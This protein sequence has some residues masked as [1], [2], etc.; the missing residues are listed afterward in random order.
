[1]RRAEPSAATTSALAGPC[2]A[3]NGADWCRPASLACGR[4]PAPH[5]ARAQVGFGTR[6]RAAGAGLRARTLPRHARRGAPEEDGR[7]ARL[8]R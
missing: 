3:R 4:P 1:M 2:G 7:Q 5:T 6:A 8:G